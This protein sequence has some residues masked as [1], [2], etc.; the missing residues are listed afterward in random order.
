M[1]NR[2]CCLIIDQ[3]MAAL[4]EPYVFLAPE[5]TAGSTD[6]V[7]ALVIFKQEAKWLKNETR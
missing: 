1:R 6:C 5:E 4:K 2:I 7:K 3:L